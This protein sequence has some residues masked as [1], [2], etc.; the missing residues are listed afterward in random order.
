MGNQVGSDLRHRASSASSS[1]SSASSS[2]KS[3][4]ESTEKLVR[5]LAKFEAKRRKLKERDRTVYVK[6]VVGKSVAGCPTNF[7]PSFI[8][9]PAVISDIS[10][11]V[12]CGGEGKVLKGRFD[13]EPVAL[14]RTFSLMMGG[15]DDE[16]SMEKFCKEAEIMIGLSHP[17][18]VRLYVVE[19]NTP[20][21]PS[22]LR[23]FPVVF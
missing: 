22:P 7:L 15:L 6:N 17:N 16:E 18:I 5:S 23:P 8:I 9:D 12:G 13:G 1:S 21:F 11:T 2:Q 10:G 20:T 4:K 3:R 14:K 19:V